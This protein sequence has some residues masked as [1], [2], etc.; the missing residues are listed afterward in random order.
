MYHQYSHNKKR[1][2]QIFCLSLK[3]NTPITMICQQENTTCKYYLSQ[4]LLWREPK[5]CVQGSHMALFI[6]ITNFKMKVLFTTYL[7][8]YSRHS[9]STLLSLSFLPQSIPP[10]HSSSTK[11]L[12]EKSNRGYDVSKKAM[13]FQSFLSPKSNLCWARAF[14]LWLFSFDFGCFVVMAFIKMLHRLYLEGPIFLYIQN[15]FITSPYRNYEGG[16]V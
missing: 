9:S 4:T 6:G 12:F 7:S 15:S 10:S 2:P 1:F 16:L 11:G 14:F 5:I 3:K 8:S 13:Y